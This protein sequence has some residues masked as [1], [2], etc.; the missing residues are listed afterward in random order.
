MG[1]VYQS[2][3]RFS[4]YIRLIL[5]YSWDI[6]VISHLPGIYAHLLIIVDAKHEKADLNAVIADNHLSVPV[7]GKLLKFLT[8][9]KD[10]FDGTR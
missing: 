4:S 5:V 9:F 1:S 10:L 7:Q 2:Y 6:A 8:K 3:T